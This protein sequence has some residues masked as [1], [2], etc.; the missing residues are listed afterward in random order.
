MSNAQTTPSVEQIDY[1][2]LATKSVRS[3][4]ARQSGPSRADTVFAALLAADP[5]LLGFA[6]AGHTHDDVSKGK[7]RTEKGSVGLY[8]PFRIYDTDRLYMQTE[9]G[10]RR[11]QF[12]TQPANQFA[13]LNLVRNEPGFANGTLHIFR[14]TPKGATKTIEINP[15]YVKTA[16]SLIQK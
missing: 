1:A 15:E 12:Q 9:S 2:A 3:G 8:R 11:L 5:G 14:L 16:A 10:V 6:E 13:L 4:S 7:D